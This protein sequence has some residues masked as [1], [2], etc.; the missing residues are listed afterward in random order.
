MGPRIRVEIP[1]Y[2]GLLLAGADFVKGSRFVQGGGTED[3]PWIP[4]LWQQER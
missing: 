2:V 4:T 1:A 3:M